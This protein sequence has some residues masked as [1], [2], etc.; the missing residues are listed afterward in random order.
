MNKKRLNLVIADRDI[1]GENRVVFQRD[2]TTSFYIPSPS[3]LKRLNKLVRYL[4][5]QD[6]VLVHPLEG[7]ITGWAA[8]CHYDRT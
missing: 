2:N 3:S 6:R 8:W 4:A 7:N 1:Y 5:W